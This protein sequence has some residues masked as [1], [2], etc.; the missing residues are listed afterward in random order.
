MKLPFTI[1][2]LRFTICKKSLRPAAA[3][4]ARRGGDV[5]N[6]KSSIINH[7]SQRAFT[8]VEVAIS[9]AIIGIALVGI[10]GVLPHGLNAQRENREST[11]INQDA[12]VFMDAIS[13]GAR[14]ADDLANYVYAITNYQTTLP[15][16]GT[17]TIFG[18]DSASLTNGVRI[19]GLLS[20]P[21]FVDNSFA[22]ASSVNASY[23]NHVT[24]YVRSLSGP[25]VEKPPQ[26]N[27]ILQQDY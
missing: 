12:T 5:K 10:I 8:M 4:A 20:T 17:T 19:V 6:R 27:Q 3:A 13:K 26:G 2:D 22:P 9:L 23:S 11:I 24:A 15:L 21:E 1:Y 16:P 18:Y 14:G 7:Q 25:A